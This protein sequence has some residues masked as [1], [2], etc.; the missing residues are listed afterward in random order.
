MPAGRIHDRITLWSLP[1]VAGLTLF[2]TRS[3]RL[4]L[5][6]SAS[7]LLAGLMLGPD[8]D[9]HSRQFQRWGI[10]RWIWLP[11]QKTVR[12]RSLLSHGLI[13]GTVVRVL[14]LAAWLGLMLGVGTAI[15]SL[16]Q[17][18]INW[19]PVF[20]TIRSSVQQYPREWVALWVGLELG[21]FSHLYSDWLVSGYK[22]QFKRWQKSAQPYPWLNS[23]LS[24]ID[25]NRKKK[26][27]RRR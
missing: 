25:P 26:A 22:R 1:L 15:A 12:H 14:Y 4:T 10:L 3:S 5:I 23:M 11:Y 9:I 7:F 16:W 6:V 19:Q 24:R 8:L 18:E 13:V 21:A 27:R 17:L 20:Q 2:V